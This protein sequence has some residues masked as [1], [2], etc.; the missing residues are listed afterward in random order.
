MGNNIYMSYHLRQICKL[1]NNVIVL[2]WKL[3]LRFSHENIYY[4]IFIAKARAIVGQIR[5][6][7][8]V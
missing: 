3:T 8:T 4:K 1:P 6:S 5:F 7:L 2:R